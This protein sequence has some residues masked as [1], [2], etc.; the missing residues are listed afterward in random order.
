MFVFNFVTNDVKTLYSDAS[1][2]IR[3]Y[4][5][6]VFDSKTGFLA[7]KIRDVLLNGDKSVAQ[8]V[9]I[10]ANNKTIYFGKFLDVEEV[11]KTITEYYKGVAN[12]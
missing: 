3:S 4:E 8:T 7:A 10:S 6:S 2:S 9:I 1:L 5:C 11:E 12:G